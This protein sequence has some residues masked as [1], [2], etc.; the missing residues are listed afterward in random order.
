MNISAWNFADGGT[1]GYGKLHDLIANNVAEIAPVARHDHV[2][3]SVGNQVELELYERRDG[4]AQ[5]LLMRVDGEHINE[6]M[7]RHE[8]LTVFVLALRISDKRLLIAKEEIL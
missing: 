3:S 2:F 8:I 5:P 4:V 6:Y 7:Y 1:Q